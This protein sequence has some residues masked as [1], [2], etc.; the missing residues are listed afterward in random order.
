[1]TPEDVIKE[2]FKDFELVRKM[3]VGQSFGEIA[4]REQCKRTAT[5]VCSKNCHFLTLSKKAYRDILCK[6]FGVKY[7]TH[8]Q[9]RQPNGPLKCEKVEKIQFVQTLEIKV[10]IPT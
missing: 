1:M 9:Q 4:L 6:S 2:K 7:N 8:R 5:I 3:G 10:A